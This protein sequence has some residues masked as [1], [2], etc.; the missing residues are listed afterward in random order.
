[1]S[2]N[3]EVD[4]DYESLPI[5]AGQCRLFFPLLSVRGS[6]WWALLVRERTGTG[7]SGCGPGEK[8]NQAETTS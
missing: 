4:I 1:M 3:S 5:G 8:Q 7:V 2:H 6:L